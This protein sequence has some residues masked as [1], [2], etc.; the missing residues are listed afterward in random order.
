MCT[1]S[2]YANYTMNNIAT[3]TTATHAPTIP[4]QDVFC[5]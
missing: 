2:A 3:P 4:L 1:G 5:L